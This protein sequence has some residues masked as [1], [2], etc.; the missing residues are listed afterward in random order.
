[1]ASQVAH[2]G[3]QPAPKN[4]CLSTTAALLPLHQ[5]P[6]H[7]SS[8]GYP[9]EDFHCCCSEAAAQQ[10]QRQQDGGA[11]GGA[12]GGARGAA[13]SSAAGGKQGRETLRWAAQERI[14]RH[15]AAFALYASSPQ[16]P[17]SGRG[18]P[19]CTSHLRSMKPSQAKHL[20]QE[21]SW[22]KPCLV[23][24]AASHSPPPK[25]HIFLLT[26]QSSSLF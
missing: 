1:M 18:S 19:Q 6:Q 17:P 14:S 24:Q 9:Q 2:T 5:L 7:F 26:S 22:E 8:H 3:S 23:C 20:G 13:R 12:L 4:C 10:E 21:W 11:L 15:T 16:T 25:E